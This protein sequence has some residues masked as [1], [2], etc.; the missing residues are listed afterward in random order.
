M[1]ITFRCLPALEPV[2]PKPM[3]AKRGLP[4]W[5]RRMPMTATTDDY[6][7]EV[8]T[9]KQCPPFVDAMAFG[10][11]MPLPC[12]L[13]Y[14]KGVFDWRWDDL[15]PG[16][17]RHTPRAPVSFHVNAQVLETPLFEEDRLLIKF[18]NFW[19][20]EV[21]AGYSLLICHPINRPDLPFRALTGL[22]DADRYK[23]NYVHFPAAWVDDDFEGTVPRGTPVAQCIPVPRQGFE[24]DFQQLDD[25]AEARLATVQEEIFQPG[26]SYRQRFREK[27]S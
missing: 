17:P 4:D 10:F 9:V 25:A 22:V 8:K 24:L 21:D 16:L 15:P 6:E 26:G 2:L 5:L 20:M 11:L 13:H 19:T 3:P 18:Q 27:K 12:D 7:T 1:R 14:G 23:D